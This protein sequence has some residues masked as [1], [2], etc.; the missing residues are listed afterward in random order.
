MQSVPEISPEELARKRTDGEDFVLLDVREPN[1][2]QAAN[3]GEGVALAPMSALVRQGMEA[4]PDAARDQKAEMVIFCHHGIRSA[5]VVMWLRQRGWENVWNLRGGI[6]A[7]A[8]EVDPSV[9]SY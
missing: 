8:Q 5:Q 4:L 1:E 9:G 2:L 6:D 3:L 7:Y